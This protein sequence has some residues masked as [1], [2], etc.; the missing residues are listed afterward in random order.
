MSRSTQ[1]I[2]LSSSAT[3]YIEENVNLIEEF[4]LCPHCSGKINSYQRKDIV[5]EK[6]CCY[7]MF[8]EEID[9]DTWKLKDGGVAREVVQVIPWSSGPVI[10]TC[11][12]IYN[13]NNEKIQ[14]IGEW[15]EEE[16]DSY[17]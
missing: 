12:E 5:D 7:G 14:T 15:A 11:L 10:F 1:F 2:G 4:I 13:G 16:M 6:R 9:L 8:D 3:Q 17:L